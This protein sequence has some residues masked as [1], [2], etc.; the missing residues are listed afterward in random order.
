MSHYPPAPHFLAA[1]HS[2]G[3]YVPDELTG[4]QQAYSTAAG[5]PL[6]REMVT[7]DVNHPS[8]V[9]WD[10]GNEGGFN[11]ELD[12][13]FAQYDP[14]HRTV[15]HPWLNWNGINT[16]HYEAYDCC[17]GGSS[18]FHGDDL[19]MPTEFVHALYDGG[20]GAGLDDWWREMLAHPLAIGGFIWAFADEGIVR[21][22]QGG[23]IDVA[24]NQAPDG[25]VGP[26]R[27]KEG[28]FFAVKQI[29]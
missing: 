19:I 9:L 17:A 26:Y 8:I 11:F 10:N 12:P 29:W 13:D 18:F 21:A 14:Q 15:I 22:D 28:S 24:G 25:L 1:A 23:A 2:L 7:R 4:W 27:K 6:V 5:R 3:L 20:G 16:G